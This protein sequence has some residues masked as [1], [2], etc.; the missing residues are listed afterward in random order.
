MRLVWLGSR[1]LMDVVDINCDMYM[2]CANVLHF[3]FKLQHLILLP[4]THENQNWNLKIAQLKRK[5]IFQ[6]KPPFFGFH[7]NFPGCSF[8]HHN[9][10]FLPGFKRFVFR[11]PTRLSDGTSCRSNDLSLHQMREQ[12]LKRTGLHLRCVPGWKR[13][14]YWRWSSHLKNRK[15]LISLITSFFSVTISIS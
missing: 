8:K 5:L 9:S 1:M 11:C 13:P 12:I 15:I 14:L 7:V 10:Q 6:I 4:Y 3:I 2:Q